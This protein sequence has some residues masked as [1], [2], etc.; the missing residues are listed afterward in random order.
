MAE[1]EEGGELRFDS[2]DIVTMAPG[3][4]PTIIGG[5]PVDVDNMS[6]SAP[7]DGNYL[8]VAAGRA[9]WVDGD[10]RP[11]PTLDEGFK[12]LSSIYSAPLNGSAPQEISFYGARFPAVDRCAPVGVTELTYVVDATST[13]IADQLPEIHAATLG[14]TGEVVDDSIVWRGSAATPRLGSVGVCGDLIAVGF[15][16]PDDSGE[17]GNGL[18]EV[19]ITDA[20]GSTTISLGEHFGSAGR[21]TATSAGV[22]FFQ[23][24]NFKEFFWSRAAGEAYFIGWGTSFQFAVASDGSVVT[25]ESHFDEE[26]GQDSPTVVRR[27]Q[28]TDD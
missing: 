15:T 18:R 25:Q 27:L 7:G 22:F 10:V 5:R 6:F 12:P 24:D 23:W 28:V 17:E 2:Y 16:L 19:Q 13:G 14:D 26:A 4:K 8:T 1:R 3:G 21:V 9:W 20:N 11:D